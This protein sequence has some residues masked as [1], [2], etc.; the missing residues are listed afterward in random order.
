MADDKGWPGLFFTAF[1]RSD[2]AMA[3]VD[4]S[5]RQVDVNRAFVRLLGYRRD[6]LIGRRIYEFVRGGPL[7][8][9]QEWND[10]V[11]RDSTG[12]VVLR[13]ADGSLVSAQYAAHPETVT[14]R[15][16]V[17]FV[18]LSVSRAG[19]HFRREIDGT[20]EE[21]SLS[22]RELEVVELVALGSSG[23]EIA[24]KLYISHNTVRTHVSNA[25]VKLG[26]RSRAQLVAK[27]LAQGHVP[28]A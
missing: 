19:A 12:K 25:M 22:A 26:A 21:A 13:R 1:Q 9:E 10:A 17:L 28:T 23:P 7:L 2:N 15:L 20:E 6:A 3:L 8:S 5:R 18:A 14:G 11:A 4:D 27:A 24:D 16:L